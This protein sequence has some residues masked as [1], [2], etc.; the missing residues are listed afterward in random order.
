MDAS[1]LKNKLPNSTVI[2]DTN[3]EEIYLIN[4]AFNP[5]ES[6]GNDGILVKLLQAINCI[7]SPILFNWIN[8]SFKSLS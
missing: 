1:F 8:D 3:A 6:T 2:K 7:I 5:N 4:S